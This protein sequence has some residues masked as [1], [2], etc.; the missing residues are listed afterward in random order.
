MSALFYRTAAISDSYS[1]NYNKQCILYTNVNRS[2]IL[3]VCIYIYIK[4]SSAL[5]SPPLSTRIC[6]GKP[7]L[8]R[9]VLCSRARFRTHP[10]P[11]WKHAYP[12]IRRLH[13]DPTACH[14]T[15]SKCGA[16][17]CILHG[18]RAEVGP[19]WLGY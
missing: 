16:R 3:R 2:P 15:R 1:D 7:S 4:P 12:F 10:I 19:M 9:C 5:C 8:V 18:G 11:I 13:C 6:S 14:R 17:G